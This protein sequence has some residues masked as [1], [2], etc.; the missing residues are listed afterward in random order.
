MREGFLAFFESKGHVRRPSASLVPA[1]YDPSVLLTTAGMQQFK[2]I[3]LGL[4]GGAPR[5]A[6][7][8]SG[9]EDPARALGLPEGARFAEVRAAADLLPGIETAI[10]AEARSLVDWHARHGFCAVCGFCAACFSAAWRFARSLR[11]ISAIVSPWASA[12]RLEQTMTVAIHKT[13]FIVGILPSLQT[14]GPRRVSS[15]PERC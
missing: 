12:Q 13:R 9:V 10:A 8:V 2:P 15:R 11:A 4:D 14:Q 7:D 5:W 6:L 3:F 1:T